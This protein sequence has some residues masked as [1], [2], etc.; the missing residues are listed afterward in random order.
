MPTTGITSRVA[1]VTKHSVAFA[2]SA[3]RDL[4][5][6]QRATG[7][8][9]PT[10]LIAAFVIPRKTPDSTLGVTSLPSITKNTLLF[11]AS[12]TSPLGLSIRQS[13]APSS[14]ASDTPNIL[15]R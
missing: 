12:V 4:R 9:R 7:F 5:V 3:G 10:E 6:L 15:L 2:R 14:T 1:L 8:R 11:D 13:S